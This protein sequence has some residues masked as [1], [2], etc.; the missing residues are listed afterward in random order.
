MP[1]N[2]TAPWQ[3]NRLLNAS[4][5]VAHIF[6]NG[7]NQQTVPNMSVRDQANGF[8]TLAWV[9]DTHHQ[10]AVAL[11]LYTGLVVGWEMIGQMAREGFHQVSRRL[12]LK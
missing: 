7:F 6:K 1:A 11:R 2:R 4:Q 9:T 8:G 10:I 12:S 3:T 5:F